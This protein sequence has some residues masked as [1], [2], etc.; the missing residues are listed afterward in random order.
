MLVTFQLILMKDKD[1]L[2]FL[3]FLSNKYSNIKS[4]IEKQVKN[5]TAFLDIFIS[6]TYNSNLTLKTYHNQSRRDVS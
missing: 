5:S 6:V 2:N 4:T 3:N 1:S